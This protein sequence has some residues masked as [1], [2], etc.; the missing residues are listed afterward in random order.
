MSEKNS[1]WALWKDTLAI[2]ATAAI[3]L[4]TLNAFLHTFNPAGT[5]MLVWAYQVIA[6]AVFLSSWVIITV[7]RWL[8]LRYRRWNTA[9]KPP[10]KGEESNGVLSNA[11]YEQEKIIGLAALLIL[12]LAIILRRVPK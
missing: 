2:L 5:T 8:C 6:V 11:K 4:Y 9:K 3:V 10:S 7:S 1:F 12:L